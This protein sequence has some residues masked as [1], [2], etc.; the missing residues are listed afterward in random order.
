MQ[1]LTCVVLL[2]APLAV[3]V[4]AT[5]SD[6]AADKTPTVKEIMEKSN[7]GSD[8]YLYG[9][10]RDLKE[11]EIPWDDIKQ[12]TREMVKLGNALAKNDPPRGDKDSWKKLTKAYGENVKALDAAARKEN[13]RTAK[14]ALAKL[15][16]SCTACHKVHR[17][18]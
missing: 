8:S 5:S 17:P 12:A 2:L 3:A 11:D 10:D 6:G 15:K 16:N 14:A 7:K 9:V 1:R 18:N 4:A 13:P